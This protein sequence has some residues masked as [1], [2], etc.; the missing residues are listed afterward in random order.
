MVAG[1]G[2]VWELQAAQIFVRRMKFRLAAVTGGEVAQ[3]R[4]LIHIAPG[5]HGFQQ[6]L[7]LLPNIRLLRL[8]GELL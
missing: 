4:G 2:I 3:K 1:N 6:P 8:P 5:V 7:L